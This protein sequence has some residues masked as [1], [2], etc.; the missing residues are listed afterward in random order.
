M[1]G[2]AGG[3]PNERGEP[4]GGEQQKGPYDDVVEA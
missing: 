3:T 4:I 1:R 2:D